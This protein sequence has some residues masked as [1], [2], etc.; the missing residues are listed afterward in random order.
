MIGKGVGRKR[1]RKKAPPIERESSD[2][3]GE[4]V[5]QILSKLPVKS[6]LRFRSVSKPWRD[7]IS[8]LNFGKFHLTETAN[9]DRQKLFIS[10][11]SCSFYSI[12]YES[13][14]CE[15]ERLCFPV[16]KYRD[17]CVFGS[18]NGLVLLGHQGDN[19]LVLWNPSIRVHKKFPCPNFEDA[20]ILTG[21]CYDCFTNDYKVVFSMSEDNNRIGVFSIRTDEYVEIEDFPYLIKSDLNGVALNGVTLN[22]VLHWVGIPKDDPFARQIVYL[23]MREMKIKEVLLPKYWSHDFSL[24]AMGGCLCAYYHSHNTNTVIVWKMKEYGVK[25]SWTWFSIYFP[26]EFPEAEFFNSN[27]KLWFTKEGEFITAIGKNQ[28]V[29]YNNKENNFITFPI[30]RNFISREGF[31]AMT[32]QDSLVL[33]VRENTRARRHFAQS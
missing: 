21:L 12:D 15:I 30:S 18:C 8:E 4:V 28:V 3:P 13:D 31:I 7:V 5:Y 25:E 17:A 33:P 23:D 2:L 32:F 1:S 16:K 9:F 19:M 14:S 22:G 27:S 10:I 20:G 6:L 29:I 11:S 26:V 24:F